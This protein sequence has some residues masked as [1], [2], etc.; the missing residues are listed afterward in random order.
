MCRQLELFQPP[1]VRLESSFDEILG[2]SAKELSEPSRRARWQQWLDLASAEAVEWWTD[3]TGCEGCTFLDG[4]WC[5][6][7]GLPCT[8]NPLLSFRHGMAGMACAGAGYE[9][10]TNG[11]SSNGIDPSIPF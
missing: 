9:T 11:G 3:S 2:R 10:D 6:L 7:M 4:N 5:K 8:V 1:P